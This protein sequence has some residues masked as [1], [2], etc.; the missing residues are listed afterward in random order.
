MGRSYRFLSKTAFWCSKFRI[1]DRNEYSPKFTQLSSPYYWFDVL[2]RCGGPWLLMLLGSVVVMSYFHECCVVRLSSVTWDWHCVVASWWRV[3]VVRVISCVF[4]SRFFVSGQVVE[5][6]SRGRGR[7]TTNNDQ[8]YG[9]FQITNPF[10]QSF[11]AD[12]TYT[13]NLFN[14]SS[15]FSSTSVWAYYLFV[16]LL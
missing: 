3:L 11:F 16:Y 6:R 15:S 10:F 4:R 12:H 7:G 8:W 2:R 1:W 9:Y 14:Y 5:G 13:Q